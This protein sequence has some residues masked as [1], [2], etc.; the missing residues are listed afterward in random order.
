MYEARSIL[1]QGRALFLRYS[2][3][4]EEQSDG[5]VRVF[6]PRCIHAVNTSLLS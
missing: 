1:G 6:E 3:V 5:A 2:Q 4:P